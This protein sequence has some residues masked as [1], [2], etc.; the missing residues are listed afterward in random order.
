MRQ[1]TG[2]KLT[3]KTLRVH[4]RIRQNV[5]LL[6]LVVLA[7]VVLAS[8]FVA[9]LAEEVLHGTTQRYDEWVLRQLRSPA[10]MTDPIGPAWFQDMWRDVTAAGSVTVL[11]VVTMACAGYLLMRR[12]YHMLALVVAAIVGSPILSL[13]LKD[14]FARPRP[15]FASPAM[16]VTTSSFPSSHSMLSAV[17]YLTLGALLAR[18]STQFRYKLY[19]ITVA[20]LI[21]ILVGLSRIYLGV[22]YP[23]DVL[24]GWSF[25][26]IW[27][28][29]CWLIARF[30]QKRGTIE[31]LD[32]L[33]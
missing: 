25:G 22:H 5:D 7:I 21:T 28:L 33:G 13:L 29:F 9:E 26:L 31:R 8:W 1:K 23:S 17:V 18:T 4:G 20:L 12:Q 32:E 11:A 24:A 16:H 2:S 14:F 15:E 10:D 19:F 6:T 30:L 3:G 27:A